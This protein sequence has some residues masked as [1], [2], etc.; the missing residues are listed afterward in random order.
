MESEKKTMIIT[1]VLDELLDFID[2]EFCRDKWPSVQVGKSKRDSEMVDKD[3]VKARIRN[4]F[5][6]A[7]ETEDTS[8]LAL[9]LNK[10]YPFEKATG[11]LL[12]AIFRCR[13]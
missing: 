7:L 13:D 9:L 5:E 4:A 3:E 1:D 6:N 11:V 2:G 12:D 8:R 10:A